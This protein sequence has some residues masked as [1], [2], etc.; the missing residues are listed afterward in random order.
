MAVLI[1][2]LAGLGALVACGGDGGG[3][4]TGDAAVGE[5]LY[6]AN[7]ALCHGR[8]GVGKPALGKDLRSNEFIAGMTDDEVAQFLEEGRRDLA[9][10]VSEKHGGAQKV[11]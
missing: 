4:V 6:G 8:G 10:A 11:A 9:E 2:G 7:C 1:V 5:K 3:G